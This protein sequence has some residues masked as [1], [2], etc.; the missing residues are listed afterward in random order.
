MHHRADGRPDILHG[1]IVGDGRETWQ[2]GYV[3]GHFNEFTPGQSGG[4]VWGWWDNEP[5]PRV[6]GVGSTIGD[7][8]VKSTSVGTSGDNEYGGGPALSAL[9]SWARSNYP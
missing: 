5:W 3:L 7:T 9:I 6:V 4:S 1:A 2:S 8:T